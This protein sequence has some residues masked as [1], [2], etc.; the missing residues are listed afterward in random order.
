MKKLSLATIILSF[1][2][3]ICLL[4]PIFVFAAEKQNASLNNQ[5]KVEVIDGVWV[6][7]DNNEITKLNVPEYLSSGEEIDLNGGLYIKNVG[8]DAFARVKVVGKID[9]VEI[10]VF[11]FDFQN[12]WI[13]GNDEYYYFCNSDKNA[14]IKSKESL[15]VIEKIVL[16][17]SFK[18][19]DKDK[20]ISLVLTLEVIDANSNEWE[21]GWANNPPNELWV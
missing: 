14:I 12:D 6:D 4:S 7:K 21:E 20:N 2:L 9:G 11:D 18:N 8:V 3:G 17:T 15:M 1:L 16:S 5:I 13:K 10:N 19:I